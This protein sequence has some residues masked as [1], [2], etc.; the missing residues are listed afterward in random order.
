MGGIECFPASEGWCR[1]GASVRQERRSPDGLGK[2]GGSV[3]ETRFGWLIIRLLYYS[4]RLMTG[5]GDTQGRS[6]GLAKLCQA[7]RAKNEPSWLNMFNVQ[8]LQRPGHPFVVPASSSQFPPS[9]ATCLFLLT[10]SCA[11]Y[12]VL[13]AAA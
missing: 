11:E 7:W 12:K 13:S 5:R 6:P 10:L 1:V 9:T 4:A 3:P 2:A 8:H